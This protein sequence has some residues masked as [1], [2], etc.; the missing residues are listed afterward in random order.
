MTTRYA[1][2]AR[3]NMV[4]DQTRTNRPARDAIGNADRIYDQHRAAFRIM[5]AWV[6]L[7][8]GEPVATVTVKYPRDGASHLWAYVHILGLPVV[9]RVSADG[10]GYD[11]GSAA[12]AKAAEKIKAYLDTNGGHDRCA[13]ANSDLDQLLAA[14]QADAGHYWY[15]AIRRL[16]SGFAVFQAV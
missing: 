10:Y 12:V 6:I 4:C 15:D 13:F 2:A 16:D 3:H 11:K 8:Y 9:V 7:Q 5:S 1:A 14:L